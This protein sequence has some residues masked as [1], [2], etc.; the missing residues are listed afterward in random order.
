MALA[1]EVDKI[2]HRS[3]DLITFL[4]WLKRSTK[5]IPEVS[6][7]WLAGLGYRSRQ[8]P[9]QTSRF[10]DFLA[11]APG[12]DKII[13][14]SL[15]LMT[16]W[17]WLQKPTKS[18]PEVSIWWLSVIGPRSR[19]NYPRSL[20]LMTFWPWLQESTK[21]IPEVSSWW[22]SGVNSRSRQTHSQ[23]SR[24]DDCLAFAPEVDKISTRN[25]RSLYR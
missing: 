18:L 13:T 2:N 6:I 5:S 22:G 25:L 19:Q 8:N 3:L 9:P 14:R 17:H 12:V 23:K 15:D 10:N 24:F 7:W 1:P 16:F 11:L 20:D 4:D 21:S